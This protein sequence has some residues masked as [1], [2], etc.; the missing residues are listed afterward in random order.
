[1]P[2]GATVSREADDTQKRQ[3]TLERQDSENRLRA[4]DLSQSF[5]VQAP[6]GAGKTELLTQRY[7]GLLTTVAAP[8]QII[9][10]TFTRKAAT[11]MRNRILKRLEAAAEPEPALDHE[12]QT[13]RLAADAMYAD[14]KHGWGILKNPDRLRIITIDSLCA[15]LVRQMPYLSRF[16]GTPSVA[17]KSETHYE[18][19]AHLTVEAVEE[20]EAVARALAYL[21]NDVG[22]LQKLI[23]D[24]LSFRDQWLLHIADLRPGDDA[25]LRAQ[26][27]DDLTASLRRLVERDLALAAQL[28][29]GIQ[30]QQ[31]MAAARYVA[32]FAPPDSDQAGPLRGWT[33]PLGS[34][35][36]DLKPWQALGKMLLTANGSGTPIKAFG[37]NIGLPDPKETPDA[38]LFKAHKESLKAACD[39]LREHEKAAAALRAL[40]I[41]PAPVY[42]AADIETIETFVEVLITAYGFL[43]GIFQDAGE[44]DF[45]EVADRA[46][47]AL[48]SAEEPSELA[49]ML[50]Y[51]LHHLLVDEF[52]DTN[53]HQIS[54]LEK[55]T[56]G[57]TRQDGRTLF[58]VGDPMQSIYRFRKADVGLFLRAWNKGIGDIR[59]QPLNLYRNNRSVPNVID[60]INTSF[61]SIFPD[62]PDPERG[63]VPYSRAIFTK[64]DPEGLESGIFVHPIIVGVKKSA[65]AHTNNDESAEEN[66]AISAAADAATNEDAIANTNQDEDGNELEAREI[67][68]IID[69]E[70][71]V[72]GNRDIAVLIRARSH[73]SSLVTEIRRSKPTLRYEAVEIESLSE[74][75]PIQDLLALTRALC[76]RADRVNWLAILRA[77]WCGLTLSDL[78][79]LAKPENSGEDAASYRSPLPTIWSLM[80][81]E[82]RLATLSDDGQF[83]LRHARDA[84]R[85]FIENSGRQSLRRQVE[86]AWL[87]LGGNICIGS[88][89]DAE[90]SDIRDANAFFR[91]LDKLD[92]TGRFDLDRLEAEIK[93]LYAAPSTDQNAGKLKFMTVH[94]A[95]GLEF[96]TVILPGLHRSTRRGSEKLLVWEGTHDDAGEK[97]LVV[98][99]YKRPDEEETH[100]DAEE[101][102]NSEAIRKYINSLEKDREGQENRRVLY[103]A[104]TRAIRSLHLLGVAKAK[105]NPKTGSYELKKLSASNGTPLGILWP[106]VLDDYEVALRKK[107]ERMVLEGAESVEQKPGL[108]ISQFV[109]KLQRLRQARLPGIVPPIE[110]TA[111]KDIA[112]PEQP[113]LAES[114]LA[115]HVGTLVHR[116]LELIAHQGVESWSEAHILKLRPAFDKWFLQQGH[117]R[118]ESQ[119]GA[120]RVERALTHAIT[121]THGRWILQTRANQGANELALTHL[122]QGATRNSIVDRTFVEDGVRWII[123]YKTA[124]HEG[125]D[126]ESFIAAKCK[127][128]SEQLERY[129]SLFQR[130]NLPIKK[131]IYFVDLNRFETLP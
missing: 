19:A 1:M 92:A 29:A 28:L 8:E 103:V 78:F 12:R 83:R 32:D 90:S 120:E 87:R 40:S 71:Q 88:S 31:L 124:A 11:E 39:Y 62:E 97:H 89:S 109:P 93:D 85:E 123:D 55:L 101:I 128:Y 61:Q 5:I 18:E 47:K 23:V 79:L 44:T 25:A 52:Q 26:L 36:E 131:A 50:D 114:I 41:C 119:L 33:S 21:D 68:N 77:P 94:K 45:I 22:K 7:L 27:R 110:Q 80:Q 76:H 100:S 126:I 81:E 113:Y 64:P 67:L 4:L 96:D 16:G 13:W 122:N 73:L 105:L 53:N 116:Y 60:W 121:D 30:T 46:L 51:E 66:P 20:K 58:V 102:G 99:P 115:P 56:A 49:L 3:G 107:V 98:A 6:A 125:S 2:R 95:K 118:Q 72:D 117:D 63:M 48:G 127:E 24:M 104:T 15:S 82:S 91:L 75:Q 59:L 54:L 65:D 129:A 108:D 14:A 57:W 37:K 86:G 112:V 42:A 84:L 38:K 74:R 34:A 17:E 9:A 10:I 35:V 69:A 111:I 130:D 43:W 106:T 70:W